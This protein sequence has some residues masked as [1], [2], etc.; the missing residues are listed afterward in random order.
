MQLV[1][2]V[3][4]RPVRL[5]TA[6]TGFGVGISVQRLSLQRNASVLVTDGVVY[7][8]TATQFDAFWQR[9]ADRWLDVA[10]GGLGLICA[11]H[12]FPF[13]RWTSLTV[14]PAASCVPTATHAFAT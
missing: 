4:A 1:G 14:R 2:V 5:L 6:A 9:T 8:P 12:C 11:T 3:H 7:W 10:P 13:Q